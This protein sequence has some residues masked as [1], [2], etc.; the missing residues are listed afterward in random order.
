MKLIE[1][2]VGETPTTSKR[3]VLKMSRIGW[4]VGEVPTLINVVFR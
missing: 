1:S 2:E 4:L 3:R